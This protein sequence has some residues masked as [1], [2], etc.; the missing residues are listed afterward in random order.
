MRLLQLRLENFQGTKAATYDFNGESASIYGDNETGKT[1]IFNAFTWVLFNSSSTDSKN[2]TPKTKS[3]DGDVHNL[4]H[5]VTGRF[6]M[7]DGRI[8]TLRKVFHEIW[9]KK[10]GSASAEFS[11][12]SIDFYLDE[13]PV[14]EKDYSAALMTFCGDVA[15]M[16][17]LAM[18][19]YFAETMPWES[20]RKILL[21]VCGDVTDDEIIDATYELKDLPAFLA[22]PG[23][24]GQRYT[25]DE[26][27][28]VAA[29][30]KSAINK[31]LQGIPGR[32]DEA[33]R[34]IPETG[35]CY[36]VEAIEKELEALAAEKKLLTDQKATI[37]SD[38]SI[39]LR[40]KISDA[41]VKM[42]NARTAHARD[43]SKANEEIYTSIAEAQNRMEG[44]KNNAT[45][46]RGEIERLRAET[47]RMTARRDEMIFEYNKIASS[48]WDE[49]E[50]VCPTCHRDLPENEVARLRDEFN[51]NKSNRLT[52]INERGK[53]E[54][55]KDIIAANWEKINDLLE[56][57]DGLDH[58]IA[59]AEN[60][61]SELRG[62][63][64]EPTPFESSEEH[65]KISCEIARYKAEIEK[66][67]ISG[68]A[69]TS[70]I[71]EQIS[72]VDNKYNT[73][74]AQKFKWDQVKIQRRRIAE[75]EEEEKELSAQYERL[76]KGIYLCDMFTK[77]KVDMLT[78][79]INAKF[80][81]VRFRL[82][83]E[84]VNGGVKDD[85]EIIV[86]SKE[87]AMV[88]FR[89]AN[90]AGRINAGLEIINVLSEHW[91][92]SMPVFIDNAEGVTRVA[93]I[94]TQVIRLVVSAKDAALRLELDS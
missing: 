94:C 6:A 49:S 40:T 43:A 93:N 14:K 50:A 72:A 34:A 61:I 11:G 47:E 4:D 39:E 67:K 12:H 3:A 29:S 17:M 51:V 86:P 77:T 38:N 81:S 32:I 85:C 44:I 9:K 8:V 35:S 28:K 70:A 37:L 48:V 91:G 25:V 83:I 60:I 53:M 15:Q 16:K 1:T 78:D 10:R 84:Q 5:A 45:V 23:T 58:D 46:T 26:Y 73:L 82:F 56:R 87:G 89:T 71:D 64:K 19:T 20:R 80:K 18:P 41:T 92:L 76:E 27:K 52:E 88:P 74:I 66:G 62:K 24:V 57:K 36:N 68:E 59:D 13:V 2:F 79:R 54:A 30:Q 42:E 65:R 7:D 63:L 55:N 69:F 31:Q 22:I 21:A 90:N 33:E 75:L